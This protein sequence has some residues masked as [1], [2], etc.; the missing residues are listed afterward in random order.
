M[1]FLPRVRA[2][3]AR[4]LMKDELPPDAHVIARAK[5]GTCEQI[6]YRSPTLKKVFGSANVGVEFSSDQVGGPYR[7]VVRDVTVDRY[8]TVSPGC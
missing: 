5:R 6:E 2:S 4:L 7:D 1:D 8:L 3:T